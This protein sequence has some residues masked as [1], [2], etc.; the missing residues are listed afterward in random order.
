MT[1][2]IIVPEKYRP[3]LECSR[4]KAC[5]M[6]ISVGK[7]DFMDK[8]I[9]KEYAEFISNNFLYGVFLVGDFPKRWNIMA[10]EGLGEHKSRKR[11]LKAGDELYRFLE[12][13][14]LDMPNIKPMRWRSFES[15]EYS[16]NL[17]TLL[18][19]YQSNSQFRN[20][21]NER[22]LEFLQT[23]SNLEKIQEQVTL[24]IA[25]DL[26][27]NYYLEEMALLLSV[28]FKFNHPLVEIYPQTNVVQE[29]LQGRAYD[30]CKDL[31]LSDNRSFI[32]VHYA[33]N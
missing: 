17:E 32:E 33:P 1:S 20:S 31:A 23:P 2:S 25:L 9:M 27:K 12:K 18:S 16:H 7:K 28:P 14:T 6:G 4:S 22:V 3:L 5:L 13:I 21:S 8:D 24:S 10:L 29:S 30:F 26:S 11:A 15:E 19:A